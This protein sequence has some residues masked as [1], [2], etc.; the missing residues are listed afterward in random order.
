MASFIKTPTHLTV[1][2]DDGDVETVYTSNPNYDQVIEALNSKDWET[3]RSLA[4]P[5]AQVRRTI[6]KSTAAEK[7][8][9][10]DG[11]VYYNEVPL[12]NHLT[13]RMLALIDEGIDV[14]PFELFLQN[15][16]EN[17]SY[18]AVNEL[19]GFL[20]ASDLPITEDGHFLAYKRITSDWKDAYTRKI[21]NSIG[22]VVEVDRNTVDDNKDRTC[23]SG[24]HFCSRSYLPHYGA[25]AGGRVVIVKINPKDVVSIPSDYDNAKGRCCRYEVINEIVLKDKKFSGMPRGT[26]ERSFQS[27]NTT[28]DGSGRVLVQYSIED[29]ST[30]ATFSSPSKASQL[31][32]I[33]AS[34]ISKA[35]RGVRQ[36]A[37]GYG[38]RYE[39]NEKSTD[40]PTNDDI[41]TTN[42]LHRDELYDH[43]Y[44]DDY[45]SNL[46]TLDD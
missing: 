9:I 12:H 14:A 39:F 7:V 29:G 3:V 10:A 44:W 38:W 32:G 6:E 28:T 36:S 37:G 21:D 25:S 2:F 19:Y 1:V 23:S 8:R 34:G 27:T 42:P 15:L 5:A 26:L 24:L 11:I 46:Y 18:R 45:L 16:M 35:A 33:D 41:M 22:A 43:E 4:N 20:E 30:I 40:T 31:T 13:D 17:V